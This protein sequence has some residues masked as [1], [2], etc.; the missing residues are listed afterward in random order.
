MKKK[1]VFLLLALVLI[2]CVSGFMLNKQEPVILEN[3][4]EQDLI[5]E[6]DFFIEDGD[7][8]LTDLPTEGEENTE[9]TTEETVEEVDMYAGLD[10]TQVKYVD[11]VVA[12]VNKERVK[13]G[14][15]ELTLHYE[16]R[17]AAQVRA[18]ECMTVFSHTRPNGTSFKTAITEAGAPSS[19]NGENVALGYTSAQHVVKGWMS[20]PGH[21]DNILNS[22]FNMIGVGL[23]KNKGN[24]YGGYSWC[25]LFAA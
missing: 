2:V 10:E 6:D 20:S 8:P 9:E 15:N 16:L 19:Y 13:A 3:D 14:L 21:R 4:Y 17:L 23:I 1:Y 7:I 24:G 12:L 22:R 5:G 25:Q 11:E 18:E